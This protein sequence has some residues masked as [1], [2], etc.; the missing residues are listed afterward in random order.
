MNHRT[1]RY[2]VRSESCL[3]KT[4]RKIDILVVGGGVAS[5]ESSDG[6][7]GAPANKPTGCRGVGDVAIRHRLVVGHRTPRTTHPYCHTRV[8]NR[9]SRLF[10]FSIR[11]EERGCGDRDRVVSLKS[12][13]EWFKPTLDQF[14]IRI[15]EGDERRR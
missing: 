15:E 2:Q 10:E 11:G 4:Q 12:A 14:E 7:K 1:S 6:L 3:T 9:R 13:R 5:I 8:V